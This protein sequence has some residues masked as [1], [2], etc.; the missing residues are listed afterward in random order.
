MFGVQML[1]HLRQLAL[2]TDDDDVPP[3]VLPPPPPL[4]P[5]P[6]HRPWEP[7]QPPDWQPSPGGGPPRSPLRPSGGT[8][9][10]LTTFIAFLFG[11]DAAEEAGPT[12]AKARS[13][14]CCAM[15]RVPSLLMDDEE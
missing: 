6:L 8:Q 3:A 14:M 13:R 9:S 11:E 12:G 15:P 4:S 5:T 10:S 2:R 7:A 1:E